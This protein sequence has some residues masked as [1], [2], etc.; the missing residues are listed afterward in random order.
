VLNFIEKLKPTI[1][2]PLRSIAGRLMPLTR[3]GVYDRRILCWL[4]MTMSKHIIKKWSLF[5]KLKTTRKNWK[6]LET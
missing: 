6:T 2:Y 1:S 4:L 3:W 5:T